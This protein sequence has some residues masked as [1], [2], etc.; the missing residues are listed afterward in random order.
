MPHRRTNLL[1]KVDFIIDTLE[2]T[3][4]DIVYMEKLKM[5]MTPDERIYFT[6]QV[7][8]INSTILVLIW[9]RHNIE[10]N[11]KFWKKFL[12]WGNI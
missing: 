11:Q 12:H 3:K 8:R 4:L 7:D 1:S 5:P 10:N 2:M 6:Q 9:M